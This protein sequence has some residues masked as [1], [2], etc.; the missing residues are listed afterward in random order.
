MKIGDYVI[1]KATSDFGLVEDILE[2]S[3]VVRIAGDTKEVSTEECRKLSDAQV[4]FF[5]QA[6]SLT[7]QI[8]DKYHDD[9]VY[10]PV[11][12]EE[13]EI[14]YSSSAAAVLR[15]LAFPSLVLELSAALA[16]IESSTFSGD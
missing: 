11:Y 2:S 8:I 10:D 12:N 14:I 13:G 16:L 3:V 9:D 15:G 5:N 7:T 1:I 4:A 6:L